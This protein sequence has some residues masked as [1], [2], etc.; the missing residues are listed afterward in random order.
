MNL[1]Q[2]EELTEVQFDDTP[3][4]LQSLD[5]YDSRV[6]SLAI[7][8]GLEHFYKLDASRNLNLSTL[9]FKGACPK[10]FYL[11]VNRKCPNLFG[12]IPAGFEALQYVYLKDN[13]LNSFDFDGTLPAIDILDL[14]D[15]QLEG[16]PDNF[17]QLTSLR[18]LF[19]GGNNWSQFPEGIIPDRR[20]SRCQSSRI[21]LFA[22]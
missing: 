14:R 1:S 11:D 12:H 13:Q 19:L 6:Q 10:L 17:H 7:P 18:N 21:D 20:Q 5:V 4:Y 9:T 22:K 8:A 3:K 16:F 2:N 15:N